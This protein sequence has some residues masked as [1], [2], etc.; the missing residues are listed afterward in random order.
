LKFIA[1]VLSGSL[2][3]AISGA[4]SEASGIVM[5]S[6]PPANTGGLALSLAFSASTRNCVVVAVVLDS[7]KSLPNDV[8]RSRGAEPPAR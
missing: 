8:L 3:S 7:A 2:I 1:L 4:I 5:K 6:C